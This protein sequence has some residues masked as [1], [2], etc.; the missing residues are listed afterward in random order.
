MQPIMPRLLLAV[1]F[2]TDSRPLLPLT[3]AVVSVVGLVMAVRLLVRAR[4]EERRTL[5]ATPLWLLPMPEVSGKEE[6][7]PVP[8]PPVFHY[9]PE[10]EAEDMRLRERLERRRQTLTVAVFIASALAVLTTVWAIDS[11][12]SLSKPP[13]FVF[14]DAPESTPTS[15]TPLPPLPAPGKSGAVPQGDDPRS[16]GRPPQ[17]R[18]NL[19]QTPGQDVPHKEARAQIESPVTPAPLPLQVNLP[20][21]LPPAVSPSSDSSTAPAPAPAPSPAPAPA[22]PPATPADLTP[23]RAGS[24]V[25]APA[26]RDSSTPARDPAT[27]KSLLRAELAVAAQRVVQAINGRDLEALDALMSAETASKS[28]RRDRLLDL[29]R[30]FSPRATLD[31]LGGAS[32]AGDRGQAS[33]TISLNWRGDFGVRK[34]KSGRFVAVALRQ[35][36]GWRVQGVTLLDPIP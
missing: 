24:P 10:L 32:I 4:R 18:P 2:A 30:E 11:L 14:V 26:A 33:F 23:V 19:V 13:A 22:S 25:S 31:T 9:D 7:A 27:E 20:A 16:E 6:G 17:A 21:P 3:A 5:I 34:R 1:V 36:P 15:A 35:D 8:P 28:G 29:V 12:P